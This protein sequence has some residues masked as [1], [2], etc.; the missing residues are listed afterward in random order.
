MDDEYTIL[1]E[2]YQILSRQ[3]DDLKVQFERLRRQ[4]QVNK[5]VPYTDIWTYAPAP[6]YK[7]KHLCEK[8]STMLE[9]IINASSRPGDVIADFFMGSGSTIKAAVKLN[10]RAI[11]V[12]FEEQTFNKTIFS[13]S[14]GTSYGRL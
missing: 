7:G 1:N 14:R 2:N 6:Y 11:G 5:N 4:F 8:P 3:Y 9:D 13:I 12:E 10:R